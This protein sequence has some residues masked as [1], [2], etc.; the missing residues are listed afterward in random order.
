MTLTYTDLGW[1][2]FFQSQQDADGDLTPYRISAV[3]RDKLTGLSPNGQIQLLPDRLTGEFAVGDWVLANAADQV[4][5]RLERQTE[6]SRRAAGTDARVQLIAANV[7]VL[8][9]TTSCNADFNLARLE[10]YLALAHQSG[11][12]PVVVLT[13]ADV[14]EDAADFRVKAESLAP[15][16]SVL[17]LNAKDPDD[18]KQLLDWVK[19]GQ[20]AALVGS[21]GVGKT[22][23]TNGLT[24]SA[25]A[26]RDIRE[27][28]AKGRHTTTARYLRRMV[29]GGWLI[30]TPGMRALRIKDADEGV[31]EVFSDITETAQSCRFSDCAHNGEPGC[32]V[33]AA[34]KDGSLEQERVVRW[35][36]LQRDEERNSETLLQSRRRDKG[37]GKMVKSMKRDHKGRKGY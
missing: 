21:S 35:Q 6:L 32:A 18:L 23:L 24:G 31:E 13:K 1:S 14:G 7:D 22:T 25:D 27:D 36:K 9:I 20:T 4:C 11:C 17:T 5:E 12:Y 8:F 29:H 33:V 10:R 37:F 15:A 28:D 30:D 26:V 19:P 3:H 16:L 2:D 34:V